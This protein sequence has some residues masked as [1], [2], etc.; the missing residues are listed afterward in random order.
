MYPTLYIRYSKF[1]TFLTNHRKADQSNV[2]QLNKYET[3]PNLY[4]ITLKSLIV[5]HA[6]LDFSEF[7]STLLAI[8]HVINKKFHP[9]CLLVYLVK[10]QAG[11]NFFPNLLVYFGLFVYEGLQ[12]KHNFYFM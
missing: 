11:W 6:R 3:A 9:A 8:F 2:I 12:S 7:L 4:L 1:Y 10:K 5:E